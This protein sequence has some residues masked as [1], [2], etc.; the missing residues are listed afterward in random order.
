MLHR[1]DV[2]R[3]LH[4]FR[5][6][7]LPPGERGTA[8][9]CI[10]ICVRDNECTIWLAEHAPNG[11]AG[12]LA[13]P[14]GCV[15]PG[16]TVAEAAVRQLREELGIAIHPGQIL[17]ELDDFA[18]VSGYVITPFVVWIGQFVGEPDVSGLRADRV[19]TVSM[20]EIDVDPLVEFSSA[21]EPMLKWPFRHTE[22][23]APTAAIVHQFREVVLR[24]RITRVAHF[25]QPTPA[26][27]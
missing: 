11:G 9:V 8:A 16:E 3:S 13:L 22:V 2:V 20:S 23:C 18:T 1:F 5:A 25:R 21:R 10:A 17:G 6:V 7:K 27:R 19:H 14:G 15:D 12:G 4:A 24:R 26:W